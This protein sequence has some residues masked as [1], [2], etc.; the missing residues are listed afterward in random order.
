MVVEEELLKSRTGAVR[1]EF[2]SISTVPSVIHA[3]N[4]DYVGPTDSSA[5][6]ILE[7]VRAK[8]SRQLYVAD[9]DRDSACLPRS[10]IIPIS[11]VGC[12]VVYF[13]SVS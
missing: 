12:L 4:V 8:V 1:P 6:G 7:R 11:C 3:L 2:R 10:T 5:C 9:H 13:R